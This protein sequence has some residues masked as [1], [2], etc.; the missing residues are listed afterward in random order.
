MSLLSCVIVLLLHP[1]RAAALG[2]HQHPSE[3]ETLSKEGGR[4]LVTS[5]TLDYYSDP[6]LHWKTQMD[7]RTMDT[8]NVV[9]QS[10]FND[11]ILYITDKESHLTVMSATDGR[12]ISVR[13][14][15]TTSF[16]TEGQVERWTASCNSG[17]AFGEMA[18]GTQFL[19]YSV[20]YQP[21]EEEAHMGIQT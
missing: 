20:V 9:E 12:V 13:K 18:D 6:Q 16:N 14:P 11:D 2:I 21:P 19:A 8:G 7:S 17:I 10:P 1:T 15:E 3:L 5:Y 4:Q